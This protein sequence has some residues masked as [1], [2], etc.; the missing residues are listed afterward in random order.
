MPLVRLAILGFGLIGGSIALALAEREPGRWEVTAWSR[1]PSAPRRALGRGALK[2]VAPDPRSAV[3]GA[4]LVVLA[5]PPEANLALLDELGPS[6]AEARVTLTDVTSVQGPIAAR[7]A[8]IPELRFVG[9]H[10]MSG[11]ERRGFAA[12]TAALFVERPWMVLPSPVADRDDVARVRELAEACGA[13]PIEM[14]AAAHDAAVGGVSHLPLLASLALAETVTDSA[15]WPE[16]RGLAAQGWRDTTRLARGDP[17]LG[18]AIL[19]GNA[20]ALAD[21]L[22]RYRGVLERWQSTLGAKPASDELEARLQ[23]IARD[24]GEPPA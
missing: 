7:A 2:A 10:P 24:L 19:S 18:A 8:A 17:V 1:D 11:R 4:E 15:E 20:A 5:A 22:E 6:L 14:D 16:A 13:R 9:G 3:A 23:A 21:W 12:A